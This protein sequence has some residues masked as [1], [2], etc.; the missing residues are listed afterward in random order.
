MN[1]KKRPSYICQFCQHVYVL[2]ETNTILHRYDNPEFDYFEIYCTPACKGSVGIFLKHIPPPVDYLN[3]LYD[4]VHT[5][6]AQDPPPDVVE[7]FERDFGYRPL[8]HSELDADGATEAIQLR[9][10]LAEYGVLENLVDFWASE[11]S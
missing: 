4:I 7:H 3:Y 2:D 1:G 9:N 5:L 10:C 8:V 11:A 6:R